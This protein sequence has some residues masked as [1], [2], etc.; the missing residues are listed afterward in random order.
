M[1]KNDWLMFACTYQQRL[2]VSPSS[3]CYDWGQYLR[4]WQ[5]Y[6][7]LM[8][9]VLLSCCYENSCVAKKVNSQRLNDLF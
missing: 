6:Q 2:H 5:A 4:E 8:T 7:T 3:A 1:A 9:P